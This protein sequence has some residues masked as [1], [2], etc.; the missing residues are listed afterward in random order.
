MFCLRRE[1]GRLS[2][3]LPMLQQFVRDTPR[4]NHWSPG[5]ALLYA[6]LDLRAQC[7]AEFDTL[8]WHRASLP[9][10][11]GATMTIV[12]FVAEVCVYL[13]D[14]KRAA[15]LYGLLEGHAGANLLA[16]SSGPCLGSTDRL[17]G[18]LA[19]VTK[20]WDAA[21]RHFEAAL[22]M[23][24]RTGWRVW[25][26]HTRYRYALMLHQRAAA[27]DADRAHALLAEALA[28]STALEMNALTPRIEALAGRSP[29]RRRP[30]LAG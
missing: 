18:S 14:A 24:T 19:T 29:L 15:L 16:D 27:G 6:E 2:E 11:D 10:T 22:A 8:P 12:I 26:A 17:L 30:T 25:L 3:A 5:L 28:D 21:Q 1:Q 23:D 7:Q 20:Q 13:G 9:P 4:T